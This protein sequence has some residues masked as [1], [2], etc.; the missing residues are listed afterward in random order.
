M[1]SARAEPYKAIV[2][3]FRASK[4][5]IPFPVRELRQLGAA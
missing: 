1:V 2:E 4:L 3:R 5:D